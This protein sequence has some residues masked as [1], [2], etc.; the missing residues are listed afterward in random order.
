MN[1][2]EE[3]HFK[4]FGEKMHNLYCR[5]VSTTAIFISITTFTEGILQAREKS[6]PI[7]RSSN[8]YEINEKEI[9][10]L[11][12]GYNFDK[13]KEKVNEWI[14]KEKRNPVPYCL[15]CKINEE[16]MIYYIRTEIEDPLRK[17]IIEDC[18][19]IIELIPFPKDDEEYAL[20]GKAYSLL[21][22]YDYK[23]RATS[24]IFSSKEYFE[25]TILN[26]SKA[27]ELGNKEAHSER[28]HV[29]EL[30]GEI[31]KALEDAEVLV[32]LNDKDPRAY[33]LRGNL[34]GK[35]NFYEG[36]E[37]LNRAVELSK[38]DPCVIFERAEY[39]MG[40]LS[41]YDALVKDLIKAAANDYERVIS[42]DPKNKIAYYHLGEAYLSLGEKDKAIEINKKVVELDPN[43]P[44]AWRHLATAYKVVGDDK[45]ALESY[46]M[47]V[48]TAKKSK[49]KDLMCW[50]LYGKILILE[51][52]ENY[53]E[54]IKL[55]NKLAE[56]EPFGYHTKAEILKKIGK[57]QE[58]IIA[59]KELMKR[60]K[61]NSK[62][63][64]KKEIEELEKKLGK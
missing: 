16:M 46:E 56:Y 4:K 14:K 24:E 23:V 7:V 51:K 3:I 50:G 49:R 21:F 6:I 27:I 31:D 42:L 33:I 12:K 30:I 53:E 62:L 22:E 48:N 32:K 15:R 40:N 44:S 60:V 41:S 45:N 5:L 52:M 59:Y 28:A 54:A 25:K 29:Y 43:D 1:N 10:K 35:K 63:Y 61:E 11:I 47:L 36:L 8:C 58:A 57:Y 34:K 18:R 2:K 13:A 19:K 55:C 26:L 64:Y 37:D 39:I 38:E 20:K 9:Y 17:E